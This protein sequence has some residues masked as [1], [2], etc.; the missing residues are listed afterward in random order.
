MF[1]I[2]NVGIHFHWEKN[3]LFSFCLP[4]RKESHTWFGM[5]WHKNELAMADFKFFGWTVFLRVRLVHVPCSCF[6]TREPVSA[7]CIMWKSS[8]GWYASLCIKPQENSKYY[9]YSICSVHKKHFHLSHASI[10][11]QYEALEDRQIDRWTRLWTLGLP[12]QLFIHHGAAT[13]LTSDRIWG[14]SLDE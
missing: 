3:I 9:L 13:L 14:H 1:Y 2:Y 4:Q 6:S 12:G 5:T 8:P 11:K 7:Q 10:L